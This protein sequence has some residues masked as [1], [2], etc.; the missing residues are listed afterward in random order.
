MLN[1]KTQ[2]VG[3]ENSTLIVLKIE[4]EIG[5]QKARDPKMRV[6]SQST[7][8]RKSEGDGCNSPADPYVMT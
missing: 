4:S 6:S 1:L 3:N 8:L 5:I 2:L 7:R